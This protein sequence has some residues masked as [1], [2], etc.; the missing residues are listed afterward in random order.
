MYVEVGNEVGRATLLGLPLLILALKKNRIVIVSDV[1][2]PLKT[3]ERSM[4]PKHSLSSIPRLGHGF[5]I[6]IGELHSPWSMH[7]TWHL[8]ILPTI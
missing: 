8:D 6:N 4:E 5:P 3:S 7:L 1:I 2:C